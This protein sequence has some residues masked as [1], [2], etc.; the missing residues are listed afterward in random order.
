MDKTALITGASSGIGRELAKLFAGGGYNLVLVAR[1]RPI[2]EELAAELHIKYQVTITIIEKDLSSPASPREIF[3]ELKSK[4]IHIDVLVNN[5]GIGVYG[6]FHETGFEE[7]IRQIHVNLL[8]LTHLTRLAVAE[9]L[10]K[11]GGKILNLGSTASFSPVPLA[12]IY[13]ATK[14]YVLSF[15]EAIA[16]ELEGAGVTVTTLC[17]GPTATGFADAA[18]MKG[19][20]LF[21]MVVMDPERV[22]A[23]G[24]HALMKGK[25]VA[26][27]G[28]QNKLQVFMLRFSPRR[29]ILDVGQMLMSKKQPKRR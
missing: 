5:A 29:L 22:A 14:A 24:Y 28:L 3:D 18:G 16:K 1:S 12:A 4:S 13:G 8:S 27:A 21:R 26:V 20:R 6:K 19:V 23:I 10:K 15:S 25:R 17:P 7:E 11:G 9:M 2:M